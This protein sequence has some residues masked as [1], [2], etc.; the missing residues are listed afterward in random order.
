MAIQED[1]ALRPSLPIVV[2][3]A[4]DPMEMIM[5]EASLP[6]GLR[7]VRF[8]ELHPEPISTFSSSLPLSSVTV[9]HRFPSAFRVNV[10][11]V[12]PLPT[13]RPPSS[14]PSSAT[15]PALPVLVLVDG[16]LADPMSRRAA[17]T[18]VLPVDGPASEVPADVTP[19]PDSAA[20]PP[21]DEGVCGAPAVCGAGALFDGWPVDGWVTEVPGVDV[22]VVLVVSVLTTPVAAAVETGTVVVDAWTDWTDCR[23]DIDGFEPPL[24]LGA[25]VV[26]G[27]DGAAGATVLGGAAGAAVVTGAL[28][29][30]VP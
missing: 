10:M 1:F 27:A 4:L 5:S 9:R 16:L 23:T 11:P 13:V 7:W 8:S 19:G 12:L 6:T 15:A 18:R 30:T 25:T 28:V 3:M 17:E 20:V 22:G 29:A 24:P 2:P 21:E 14:S 26:L